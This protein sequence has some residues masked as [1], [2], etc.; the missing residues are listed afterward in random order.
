MTAMALVAVIACSRHTY[1]PVERRV[2]DSLYSLSTRDE[3]VYVL[4]SVRIDAGGDTVR[5]SRYRLVY[6]SVA[7][8]DSVSRFAADTVVVERKGDGGLA[9]KIKKTGGGIIAVSL[10]VALLIVVWRSRRR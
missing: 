10:S 7:G 8:R 6:A 1:E 4:D 9:A 5:E 2:S 3:V